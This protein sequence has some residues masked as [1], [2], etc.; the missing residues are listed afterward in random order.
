MVD[1][2]PFNVNELTLTISPAI[3]F[4]LTI[5]TSPPLD[6]ISPRTLTGFGTYL[7]V[8]NN[9]DQTFIETH[10]NQT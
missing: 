7:K 9:N 6:L 2:I 1:T 8:S 5:L 10:R 3:I 4:P